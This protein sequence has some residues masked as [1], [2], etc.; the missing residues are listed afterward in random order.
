MTGMVVKMKERGPVAGVP[1]RNRGG[2]KFACFAAAMAAVMAMVTFVTLVATALAAA[3]AAPA[4]PPVSTPPAPP[5][6]RRAPARPA[7]PPPPTAADRADRA[8]AAAAAFLLEQIGKD[9]RVAGEPQAQD[10]RFGG[11]TALCVQAVLTAGVEPTKNDALARAIDWLRKAQLHGTYAVALRACAAALLKEPQYYEL[12]CK[13]A[14]W[15][16][17]AANNEGGYTYASASG[18]PPGDSQDNSN[19][20]MALLGVWSAA[21]RGVEVPTAYWNIAERYWLNQQ[22]PDGGWGYRTDAITFRAKSYGSMTAAGL[23]GLYI[24]FDNLRADDFVRCA[25]S[26]DNE[27][28]NNALNWLGKEFL[29]DENPAKGVE[30]YYYWLYCAARVGLASG[31]RYLGSHDWY[32]EGRDA[33]LTR[34]NPDGS[35]GYGDRTA[36]TAFAVLFLVRGRSPVLINK[37]RYPGKWNPRPRDAAN[38]TRWL[39]ATFEQPMGWQVVNL[40]SPLADWHE[41]PILY[42]S[43]AGPIEMGDAQVTRLRTFV[44]QGGTILS[45]AACNSGDFSLDMGKIY[46]RMFPEY[47]LIRLP[48]GHTIYS[49]QYQ[50]KTEAWLSGVSNG[51]RLLAVHAPRELSLAMQVGARP[52][53]QAIHELLANIYIHQTDRGQLRPRGAV[54]WPETT[55]FTPRATIRV[56]RL[57]H[58][59]NC[60]PE[61]LALPRLA[62]FLGNRFGVKLELSDLMDISALDAKDWPIA[63]MTGTDAFKL[64]E[65]DTAALRKFFAAGGTL[66]VDAAGGS[67]IFSDTAETLI[68]PLVAAGRDRPLIRDHDLYLNGPY[69][70]SKVSYRRD[71]SLSLETVDRTRPRLQVVYQGERLAIIHSREDI[72]TGLLDIPVFKLVGFS[73][74]SAEKL[75]TNILFHAA[76]LQPG[77]SA[78]PAA[79]AT[80]PTPATLPFRAPPSTILPVPP[81]TTTEPAASA[82]AAT[83]PAATQPSATQPTASQPAETGVVTPKL[84]PTTSQPA[85]SQPATQPLAPTAKATDGSR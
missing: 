22:Q 45:E 61:P 55:P 77:R 68:H 23:A 49:A 81:P 75:M 42:V 36:D 48:Q 51:V 32:A 8:V 85:G 79:P 27:P 18:Q 19:A 11:K 59:G 71:H 24:C 33:L 66:I 40:D 82:P 69:N 5:A 72:L 31:N 65:A 9:G 63:H 60:D 62:I 39:T 4:A 26:K 83:Q 76:G 73:P 46:A 38:L 84:A 57:R 64:S 21:Q 41:A 3:A 2:G 54:R 7:L 37:L 52:T 14:A 1:F 17:R 43:G 35:W 44:R 56:A 25:A 78:T 15:L 58:G 53:Q 20:Q 6:P 29:G 28:I 16:I 12:L 34:Q 13:D 47:P 30:W 10:T 80:P 67:R 74:D 50:P 70:L